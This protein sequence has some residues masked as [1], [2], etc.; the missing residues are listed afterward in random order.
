MT[1]ILSG[2]NVRTMQFICPCQFLTSATVHY[3]L[4]RVLFMKA[5]LDTTVYGPTVHTPFLLRKY[6][7]QTT[8]YQHIVN[9]NSQ[10]SSTASF[11]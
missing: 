10:V 4:Q 11:K 5:V 6:E 8:N 7:D 2:V 1:F 3:P 9:C